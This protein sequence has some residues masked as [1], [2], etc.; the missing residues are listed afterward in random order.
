M[1]NNTLSLKITPTSVDWAIVGTDEDGKKTLVRSGIRRFKDAVE[2]TKSGEV[3]SAQIRTGYRSLR[4]THRRT[5]NRKAD[6]LLVLTRHGLCPAVPEEALKAWKRTK[7]F[8]AIPELR[9]WMNVN[10]AAGRNPYFDRHECLHRKLDL[11]L[12][13]DRYILGRALYH[14]S[15]RRGYVGGKGEDE[16]E[17]TGVVLKDIAALTDEMLSSG[18]EFLGDYFFSIYNEKKIRC[19]YLSN[20][21]HVEAEFNE[22]CRVQEL[23]PALVEELRSCMLRYT[24][25]K[26]QKWQVGRCIYEGDRPCCKRS[27][28][29]YE[30]LT[31]LQTINNIKVKAPGMEDFHPLDN[32]Q[33]RLILPLFFRKSKP[34]FDFIE[35]A[36][37]IAGTKSPKGQDKISGKTLGGYTFNYRMDQGLSGCTLSAAII[38]ALG[39]EA[40]PENWKDV[41]LSRY[42]SPKPK[43]ADG[44]VDEIWHMLEFFD[45]PTF[46]R[47]AD[48]LT[49]HIRG[50][51]RE[52]ALSLAKTRLKSD[53]GS[54]SLKAIG[55]I[56]PFLREGYTMSHA[57][58]LA[59]VPECLPAELSCDPDSV[60]EALGIVREEIYS[61]SSGTRRRGETP[62]T[63]R[64][65][66]RM[67]AAWPDS[68][69]GN[70]WKPEAMQPFTAVRNPRTGTVRLPSPLTSSFKSPFVTRC[71]SQAGA[72]VNALLEEGEV[73]PETQVNFCL[74]ETV[75]TRNMRNA[76]YGRGNDLRK[77]REAA[78]KAVSALGLTTDEENIMR[79]RLWEEQKHVD[80]LTGETIDLADA[81]NRTR[82]TADHI[83]PLCSGG[84]DS[85][86]NRILVSCTAYEKRRQQPL[87]DVFD[88]EDIKAAVTGMDWFKTLSRLE[89]LDAVLTKKAKAATTKDAK[90][91]FISQRNQNRFELDYWKSKIGRILGD[92][93]FDDTDSTMRG[94]YGAQGKYLGLFLKSVFQ[95]VTPIG[96]DGIAEFRNLWGIGYPTGNITDGLLD[97][98]TAAC[99]DRSSYDMYV[100]YR[101]DLDSHRAFSDVLEEVALPWE[102]FRADAIEAC[103][104]VL[105]SSRF[106]DNAVKKTK[107]KLRDSRGRIVHDSEGN[108]V[109]QTGTSWR[110][111]L[112]AQSFYA[113]R[114]L[115]G[116]V[117]LTKRVACQDLDDAKKIESVVDPALRRRLMELA[118]KHGSVKNAYKAGDVLKTR[119]G[120]PI[121]GVRVRSFYKNALELKDHDYA[122]KNPDRKKMLVM[123][124][125]SYC[126]VIH[127]DDGN[128]TITMWSNLEAAQHFREHGSLP[129]ADCPSDTLIRK[130][131]LVLFHDGDAQRLKTLSAAELSGHL[132]R[133][134]K[135]GKQMMFRHHLDEGSK[136]VNGFWNPA[137]STPPA[138]I[139]YFNKTPFIIEGRDFAISRTGR[140][141]FKF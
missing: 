81:F 91:S 31:L 38:S 35:V 129:G 43:T 131:A 76:I 122:S 130:G 33:I 46:G 107:R 109:Y 58:L 25:V 83:I 108:T 71:L 64:I 86:D 34:G 98:I 3:P 8:P 75:N 115:G 74:S 125:D 51:G 114:T 59:N 133:V 88:T 37:R 121:T 12:E 110:G 137:G 17:Q 139:A 82:Y 54:L 100:K 50:L 52:E 103:R 67:K 136:P 70:I 39:K 65:A 72:V 19:R 89:K 96:A 118:A 49:A 2:H 141:T 9:E 57:V 90:D 78:A 24:K 23:D 117:T 93:R 32:D 30:E 45:D 55:K 105:T 56:L 16:G 80:M 126:M 47:Q 97:A 92:R 41:L 112:H 132:Y 11:S 124:D 85:M 123:N 22:I 128:G 116:Q 13:E 1:K 84:A 20:K 68:R 40:G 44:A 113:R 60:A 27:H 138:F 101:R 4:K 42:V 99:L 134:E 7:S 140:I 77:L 119:D 94:R 18:C 28:P 104:S 48:W 53:Y 36:S 87:G 135:L 10:A 62:L 106:V 21:G 63:D 120:F 95:S 29:A 73:T 66:E 61:F 14:L 26:S 69:P 102:G 5:R 15:Q 79:Y 127:D 111:S 6:L